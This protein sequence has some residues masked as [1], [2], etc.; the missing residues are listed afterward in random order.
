V[1]DGKASVPGTSMNGL[2]ACRAGSTARSRSGHRHWMSK[3]VREAAPSPC[4]GASAAAIVVPSYRYTGST[5]NSRISPM[6]TTMAR[7]NGARNTPLKIRL[8][9]FR[10]M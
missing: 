3:R 7:L 2:T 5:L 10:C 8:S 9:N 6:M 4:S 1:A